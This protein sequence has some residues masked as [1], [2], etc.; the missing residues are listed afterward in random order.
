MKKY[1]LIFLSL[2]FLYGF[3][4]PHTNKT[5][6]GRVS[7]QEGKPLADVRVEVYKTSIVTRTLSDGSFILEGITPG[8]H[9]ILFTHFD[10]MPGVLEIDVSKNAGKTV[11]FDLFARNPNLLNIRKEI[12]VTAEADSIIDISLPSHRTILPGSIL[13]ELGTSNIA[14]TVKNV[15]GVD[16]VGKGGYS[17]VPAIRGL[18]EHRI[19]KLNKIP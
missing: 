7:D 17:M 11:N 10:Y 15:P 5:L 2:V 6:K 8:K 4:Y 13:S 19:L 1:I 14:E 12:T 9:E 18:A 16:M 3:S